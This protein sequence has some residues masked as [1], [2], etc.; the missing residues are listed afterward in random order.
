MT[1]WWDTPHE[2][3]PMRGAVGRAMTQITVNI[4]DYAVGAGPLMLVTVGLGSCVGIA[5]YARDVRVGALAHVLLPN[6]NLSV[7]QE[8]PGKY[9]ATAIPAMVRRMRELGARGEIH[10]RLIG[11]ASM[12]TP[13]LAPG[14]MSLGA[15]NVAASHAACAAAHL[16]I[17]GQDIGGAHGRSVFFNVA[18]G[19]LLVRSMRSSDVHL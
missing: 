19:T 5:L 1:H 4:A 11:G 9:P 12:F 16:P 17:V 8:T 3:R 18:D 6:V 15:R 10:A 14:S 7:A 13:L 2:S